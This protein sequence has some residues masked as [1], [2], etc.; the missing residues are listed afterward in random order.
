MAHSTIENRGVRTANDADLELAT[1]WFHIFFLP[2][3]AYRLRSVLPAA[4]SGGGPAFAR[5]T[6]P[7]RGV[8]GRTKN[9]FVFRF[10]ELISAQ[11]RVKPRGTAKRAKVVSEHDEHRAAAVIESKLLSPPSVLPF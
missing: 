5:P 8:V 2:R 7:L 11:N 9:S 6:T 1:C 10:T 3:F 4:L